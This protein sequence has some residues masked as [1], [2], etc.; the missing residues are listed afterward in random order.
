[1]KGTVVHEREKFIKGKTSVL[2]FLQ[3]SVFV[4]ILCSKLFLHLSV[5]K[6]SFI[7]VEVYSVG[8]IM[9]R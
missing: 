6:L 4:L 1:M 9:L 5:L 8:S 7:P 3:H 2:I